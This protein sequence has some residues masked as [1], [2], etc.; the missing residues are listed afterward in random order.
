[1]DKAKAQS[2]FDLE[3]PAEQI[4]AI[5]DAVKGRSVESLEIGDAGGYQYV[6][7]TFADGLQLR[8][9]CN[10]LEDVDAIEPQHI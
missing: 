10:H 3:W 4:A 2:P 7:I 1:M 6:L 5:N 9:E 8:I